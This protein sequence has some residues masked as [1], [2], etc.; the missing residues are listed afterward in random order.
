VFSEENDIMMSA[1]LLQ[2][3]SQA[4]RRGY[5]DAIRGKEV[6]LTAEEC[7]PGTFR[8]TDYMDGYS[9]GERDVKGHRKPVRPEG[10]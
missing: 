7:L 6:Q 9:A 2:R 4:F 3:A 1:T 5:Y 10:F 8:H